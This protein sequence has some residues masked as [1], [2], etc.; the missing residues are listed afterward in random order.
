MPVV[1]A[2]CVAMAG[3]IA[4]AMLGPMDL[5]RRRLRP[6]ANTE[7][8]TRLPEYRR[9]NRIRTQMMLITITLLVLIFACAVIVAARPTGL[10]TAAMSSVDAAPED[11]MACIGAPADDHAAIEAMRF[12]ADRA[13]SLDTQRIGLTSS[14]RRVIPLTRD[15]Q[16]ARDV[17]STYANMDV[18]GNTVAPLS[19]PVSYSDYRE[20]VDD[21]LALCLSGFPQFDQNSGH[22]RSIVYVGPGD[23]GTRTDRGPALFSTD[24]VREMA[25]RAGV[26]ID[27]VVTGPSSPALSALAIATGGRALPADPSVAARL[28]EIRDHPPRAVTAGGQDR[29]ATDSPDLPLSLAL[30]SAVALAALPVVRRR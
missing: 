21:V 24:G 11:V 25:S 13:G 18:R 3:A 20:N 19:A 29:T 6:I 22:R 23:L 16:H 9:A 5:E 28:T 10:P 14:N 30:L 8:L 1:I 2:G 15:Y 12:F 17:F 4:L 7:R 27:A 26:Q